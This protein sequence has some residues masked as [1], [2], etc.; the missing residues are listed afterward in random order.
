MRHH[1]LGTVFSAVISITEIAAASVTYCVQRAVT[2]ETIEDFR[3]LSLMT[4]EILTV[5]IAEKR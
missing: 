5:L 3:I 1:A 2:E 4:R